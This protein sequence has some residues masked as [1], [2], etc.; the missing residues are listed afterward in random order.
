MVCYVDMRV[1]EVG[2]TWNEGCS[3]C[4]CEANGT[5]SCNTTPCCLY[6]GPR[7]ETLRA[8]E[9]ETFKDGCNKCRCM[10]EGPG[11]V[12]SYCTKRRCVNQCAYKN[13]ELVA[14]VTY[15]KAR[16]QMISVWDEDEECPKFCRC[17]MSRKRGAFVD[18]KMDNGEPE[19]CIYY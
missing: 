18:C 4:K 9:G 11:K 13:W 5:I 15:R 16:G 12:L 10:A 19:P 3:T 6:L 14:G 8:V 17:E 2:S 7:G 1:M